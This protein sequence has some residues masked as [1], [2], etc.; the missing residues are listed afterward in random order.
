ML[1]QEAPSEKPG[2]PGRVA[3]L[4]IEPTHTWLDAKPQL[5]RGYPPS[6]PPWASKG[7]NRVLSGQ[8]GVGRPCSRT[9]TQTW[10][11]PGVT[12]LLTVHE[13]IRH[14]LARPGA[15]SESR[16]KHSRHL[17]K[18]SYVFHSDETKLRGVF[19]KTPALSAKGPW[20]SC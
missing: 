19:T 2:A 16:R 5:Q 14:H 6:A 13:R 18:Q 17:G 20:G 10:L 11:P 4:K 3:W 12:G 9:S 7:Q 8:I 15:R 1:R